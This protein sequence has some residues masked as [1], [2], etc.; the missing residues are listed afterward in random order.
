[1]IRLLKLSED[2]DITLGSE[3]ILALHLGH[4]AI[5]GKV[6]YSTDIAISDASELQYV[7]LVL[8]N[9]DDVCYLCHVEDC[10]YDPNSFKVKP[11]EAKY[12]DNSPDRYKSESRK[13][14]ILFDSMQSI[15]VDFLDQLLSKNSGS[16]VKEFIHSRANNKEL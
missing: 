11:L 3:G 16:S 1:M 8:G 13:T 2:E 10:A 7:L 4:Y 15:S 5:H 6:T 12:R 14:W 9:V